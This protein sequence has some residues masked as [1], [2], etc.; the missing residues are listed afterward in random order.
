MRLHFVHKRSPVG[1]SREAIPLLYC[2][3]W[4]GGIVEVTRIIDALTQPSGDGEP[5]FHVV[6]PSIPGC[7]FSEAST[8]DGLGMRTIAEM[9]DSL[10]ARLGYKYYVAHGTGW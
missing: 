3:G 9:F 8:I 4:P 10:M 6:V 2:H 7:G 5:S 1:S